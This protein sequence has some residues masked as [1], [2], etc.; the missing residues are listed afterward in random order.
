MSNRGFTPR[1]IIPPAAP[2]SRDKRPAGA[3]YGK[4]LNNAKA[5]VPAQQRVQGLKQNQPA[6]SHPLPCESCRELMKCTQDARQALEKVLQNARMIFLDDT[7]HHQMDD[8]RWLRVLR[9]LGG[10]KREYFTRIPSNCLTAT[11]ATL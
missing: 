2:S 8:E 11:D 10:N 7:L 3:P 5:T 1:A 9:A 4:N 6:N